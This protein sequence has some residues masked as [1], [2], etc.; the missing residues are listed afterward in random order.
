MSLYDFVAEFEATVPAANI[1]S[2]V[3]L[4]AIGRYLGLESGHRIVDFGCGRGEM[5]CLWAKYYGVTGV[6]VDRDAEFLADARSRAEGWAI[7]S[8][9]EFLCLDAE[10]YYPSARPCHVATC[11]GASFC[12]GGFEPTVRKLRDLVGAEGSIALA[13][14]FFTQPEVPSELREYEGDC[15]TEPELFEIARGVGLEV[16]YYGR[17]SQDEWDRYIFST[18]RHE[19]MDALIE[20]PA[21]PA[22]EKRR[23]ALRRWQDMYIQY[24]QHWQGMAFM[25]LH[26]A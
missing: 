16:G 2:P 13:E 6:G 18:R 11:M 14:P 10:T 23:S 5:L 26:V 8:K 15:P 20:T 3:R 22:R 21:G 9:L 7:D 24:R 19:N 12:F 17:A 4:L 1:V 25:T